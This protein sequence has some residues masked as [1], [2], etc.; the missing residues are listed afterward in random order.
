[1][2]V[3][4]Q[5]FN[6]LRTLMHEM[7]IGKHRSGECCLKSMQGITIQTSK[8][9]SSVE[10]NSALYCFNAEFPQSHSCMKSSYLGP[11][12]LLLHF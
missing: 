6:F 8:A 1:M 5:P 9:L 3:C 7:H 4:E 10:V 11:I 2:P 12:Y